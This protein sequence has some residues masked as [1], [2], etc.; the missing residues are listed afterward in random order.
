MEIVRTDA[1]FNNLPLR[2]MLTFSLASRPA[3]LVSCLSSS[4][5]GPAASCHGHPGS[6][7]T[8]GHRVRAWNRSRNGGAEGFASSEGEKTQRRGAR[9]HLEPATSGEATG[10]GCGL[11]EAASRQGDPPAGRKG[12]RLGLIDVAHAYEARTLEVEVEGCGGGE[13]R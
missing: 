5:F 6:P 12:G 8:P 3:P 4:L 10:C 11:T 1:S 9:C 2:A 13:S 7:A